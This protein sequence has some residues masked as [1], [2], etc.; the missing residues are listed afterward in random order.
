ME[1]VRQYDCGCVS[2]GIRIVLSNG[3]SASLRKKVRQSHILVHC[4]G[5][6]KS[7][8][9]NELRFFKLTNISE[10]LNCL[11]VFRSKRKQLSIVDYWI[12][13]C[14]GQEFK[15]SSLFFKKKKILPFK[16]S[17]TDTLTHRK[18]RNSKK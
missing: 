18:V 2:E 8:S 1:N 3:R 16:H 4:L 5:N 11:P 10:S 13:T 15:S 9:N 14:F 6:N 12:Y 17:E 7:S